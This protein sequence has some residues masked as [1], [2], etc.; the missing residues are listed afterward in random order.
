MASGQVKVDSAAFSQAVSK[1]QSVIN[2][3]INLA[4]K[5]QTFL[6]K[7]ADV[8]KGDSGAA[9]RNAI[10]QVARQTNSGLFMIQAI[11]NQTKTVHTLFQDADQQMAGDI[12]GQKKGK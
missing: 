1:Q 4:G 3:M 6:N 5:E 9:F 7:L 12:S 8:W 11:S 10:T 2:T